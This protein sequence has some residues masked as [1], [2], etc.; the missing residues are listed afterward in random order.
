MCVYTSYPHGNTYSLDEHHELH[1]QWKDEKHILGFLEL[2]K[3]NDDP[4]RVRANVTVYWE[5]RYRDQTSGSSLIQAVAGE[6]WMIERA[7]DALKFILYI[8]ETYTLVPGAAL[9]DF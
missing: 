9:I 1:Q 5:A 7:P 2:T 4:E 6:S 3:I 8:S